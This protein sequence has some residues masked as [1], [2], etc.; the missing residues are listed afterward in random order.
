V[1]QILSNGKSSERDRKLGRT[2]SQS[3]AVVLTVGEPDAEE[4]F[5]V[6]HNIV[7][8]NFMAAYLAGLLNIT[9]TFSVGGK[10]TTT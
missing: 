1:I 7:P 9:E 5:S 8:F 2:I 4:K 6:L 3:G 10:I